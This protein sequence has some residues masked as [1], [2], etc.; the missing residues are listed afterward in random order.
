MGLDS[1]QAQLSIRLKESTGACKVRD[2]VKKAEERQE[3]AEG[4]CVRR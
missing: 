1:I 2:T 4:Q 3:R